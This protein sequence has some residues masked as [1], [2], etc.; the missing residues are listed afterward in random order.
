VLIWPWTNCAQSHYKFRYKS[1]GSSADGAVRCATSR[2]NHVHC[3]STGTG[4]LSKRTCFRRR[5]MIDAAEA[6]ITGTAFLLLQHLLNGTR[7]VAHLIR[8]SA[9]RVQARRATYRAL[10]RNQSRARAATAI[11][12]Q[13]RT[14]RL[15]PAVIQASPVSLVPCSVLRNGECWER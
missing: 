6:V 4:A 9:R 2:P 11:S 1:S 13:W 7:R 10:G 5:S 3:T 15:P 12:V 14:S 8:R